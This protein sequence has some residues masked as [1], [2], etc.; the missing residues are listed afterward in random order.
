MT[1]YLSLDPG[2]KTV[3][4]A[5]GDSAGA[6]ARPLAPLCRKPHARFLRE[7]AGLLSKE[8]ADALVVGLP[9]RDGQIGP[10][11]QSALALAHELRKATGL[12]VVTEDESFTTVEAWGIL[13]GNGVKGDRA[14]RRA[15]GVSA[16]LI[17]E[18]R[19]QRELAAGDC[20]SVGE[21]AT[22]GELVSIEARGAAGTMAAPWREAAAAPEPGGTP[23]D[24]AG[25][26][27]AGAADIAQE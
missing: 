23:R 14:R 20:A 21:C 15:D 27:G 3:G 13:D 1:R 9:L 24:R 12:P 7:V 22:A 26:D 4:V 18:R 19:L 6:V 2:E 16:A 11:A 10:R 5:V 8:G 17:L 25:A